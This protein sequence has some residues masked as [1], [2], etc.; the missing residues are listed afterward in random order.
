VLPCEEF[1]GRDIFYCCTF[2][3]CFETGS[4]YLALAILEFTEDYLPLSA[5]VK[6]VHSTWL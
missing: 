3:V 1:G 2:V 6:C 5:G 4:Q